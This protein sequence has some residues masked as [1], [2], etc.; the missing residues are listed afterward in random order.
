MKLMPVLWLWLRS[1]VL[2]SLSVLYICKI[3]F[4]VKG[5]YHFGGVFIENYVT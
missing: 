4:Q 5:H 3:L 2:V 1:W